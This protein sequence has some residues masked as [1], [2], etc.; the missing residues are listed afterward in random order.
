VTFDPA[1]VA[2]RA[3][4][5]TE[6]IHSMIYF[7]PEQDE[8]LIAAGLRP[9][10]MCYFASR[11]A[12]MGAVSAEVVTA[13]FYNFNPEVVARTIPR[14]WTLVEPPA[15]VAARFK[16]VDRALR[17]LL[18]DEAIASHE[19]AEL[20]AL[21]REATTVMQPEA[22]PLYAGHA[23]LEWPD[24]PHLQLWH[25]ASL[26][27]EYRGDGHL[28]ALLRHD[29]N[30]IDA[31]VSHCATGR[32]FTEDAAR[33]LRGWTEEQWEQ[34]RTRLQERGV[35]DATGR[36][37]SEDGIALRASVEAD[38]DAL[39]VA[40]WRHLGEDRTARLIEL[41]KGVSRAILAAGALPTTG[42][43]ASAPA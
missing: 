11:S 23:G 31:I 29:L 35:L 13:T 32:G 9:G 39:D 16:A 18:G 17:R 25:A 30:G 26:L 8:E 42:V 5:A 36:A 3:H 14:A 33:L 37:L 28:L 7:V 4:R 6:M 38:T 21:A 34:S 19:V 20:A 22:R 41:G 15:V 2:A 24:E 43:F 27:R 1:A 40:S 12:P 10:R